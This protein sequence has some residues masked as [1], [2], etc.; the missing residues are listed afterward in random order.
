[1]IIFLLLFYMSLFILFFN[2]F[3]SFLF[4]VFLITY[5]SVF[6]WK[7]NVA[8][9]ELVLFPRSIFNKVPVTI[10]FQFRFSLTGLT[11]DTN[12]RATYIFMRRH[13]ISKKIYK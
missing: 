12:Q 13:F 7:K 2:F 9:K 6:S 11:I 4:R 8:S 3:L 5:V 1:M 10:Y